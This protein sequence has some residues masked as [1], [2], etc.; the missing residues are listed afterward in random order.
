[1]LGT[2]IEGINYHQLGH[3][4]KKKILNHNEE[5]ILITNTNNYL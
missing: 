4:N 5:I 3:D 1:M 2:F